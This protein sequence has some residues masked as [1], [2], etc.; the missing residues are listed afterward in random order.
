MLFRSG[1][2]GD[3]GYGFA[4]KGTATWAYIALLTSMILNDLWVLVDADPNAPP[5]D[6]PDI[7]PLRPAK[8]GDAVVW[9]GIEWE[10]I[11]PI[12]GPE[13]PQGPQ[14][15]QGFQGDEG[16]QGS[17]GVSNVPGPQGDVGP[18][19]DPAQSVIFKG[20]DT[21]ANIAL[22]PSPV[23]NEAWALTDTDPLEIG[24]AHV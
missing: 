7:G 18:Q 16:V 15:F 20:I 6:D 3:R 11:G 9:T 2:Q 23:Q 14:G 24:R 1:P 4:F 12:Q 10:N 5:I 22:L 19:G 17:A 8:V 21:W 13:G